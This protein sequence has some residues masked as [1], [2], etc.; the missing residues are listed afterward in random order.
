MKNYQVKEVNKSKVKDKKEEH[1]LVDDSDD[2]MSV[3]DLL[4]NHSKTVHYNPSSK[5]I[6]ENTVDDNDELVECIM[7][8]GKNWIFKTSNDTLEYLGIYNGKVVVDG[9]T[10]PEIIA[11]MAAE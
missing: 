3:D 4:D 5:T 6:V 1:N 9:H 10:P 8:K 11:A 7:V 2:E